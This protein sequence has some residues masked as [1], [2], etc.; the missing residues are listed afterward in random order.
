MV[1]VLGRVGAL[2]QGR[3]Q[4]ECKLCHILWDLGKLHHISETWT[5]PGLHPWCP[6][7]RATLISPMRY[8]QWI[9]TVDCCLV[10]CL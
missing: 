1:G 2:A 3:P 4:L 5:E 7:S 10:V 6:G 8:E 9:P